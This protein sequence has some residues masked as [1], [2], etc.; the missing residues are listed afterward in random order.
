MTVLAALQSAAIRLVGQRPS[1]FF[2]APAT[3]VFELEMTDLVNEVA[4]DICKY[5][6]WQ[7]LTRVALLTGDGSTSDFD[8][9]AGYDRQLVNT[10]VQSPT[11]WVWGYT[12]ITDI[13][14]FLFQENSGWN[15]QPGGWIIYG[16]RFRFSPAPSGDA[17]FPYITKN[18]ALAGTTEK[19]AFTADT[20]TFLLPERLLMLALVWRW[21]ENKKLDASGDQEAFIKALDEYAGKDKGSS[22]IRYDGRRRWPNASVPYMGVAF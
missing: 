2:G 20:D 16:D 22:I 6:D 8:L 4:T 11:N 10:D 19:S 17:Q 12:H 1:T 13:N 21:R 9:P 3:A 15:L 14:S 18:Y 5:H 7:A